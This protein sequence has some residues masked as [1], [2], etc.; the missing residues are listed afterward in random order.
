MKKEDIKIKVEFLKGNKVVLRPVE[1][2]D[3]P[4]FYKWDNDKETSELMMGRFLPIS[5]QEEEK[6]FENSS[7]NRESIAFSIIAK[8]ENK[9]I[10]SMSLRNIFWKD[11]TAI[12]GTMIGDKKYWSKGYGMEAKMLNNEKELT[13][14]EI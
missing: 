13:G 1:K 12:T 7:K 4:L 2:D 3:L 10:G 11:G 9:L 6:L 8:K 5:F 14:W